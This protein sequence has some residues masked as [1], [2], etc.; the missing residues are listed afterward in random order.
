MNSCD[1]GGG[2]ASLPGWREGRAAGHPPLLS[3]RAP[4]G[5]RVAA[6]SQFIYILSICLL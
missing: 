5:S 2:K 4:E 1:L 6:G 3:A